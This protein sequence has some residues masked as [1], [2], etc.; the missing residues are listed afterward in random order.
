MADGKIRKQNPHLP[1]DSMLNMSHP[2]VLILL[3]VGME[4]IHHRRGGVN[5]EEHSSLLIGYIPH[6]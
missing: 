6:D 1:A 3:R 5:N 4:F 2:D